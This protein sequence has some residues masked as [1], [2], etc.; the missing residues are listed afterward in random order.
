MIYELYKDE[1]KKVWVRNSYTVKADSIEEAI[2][3]IIDDEGTDHEDFICNTG[4]LVEPSKNKATLEIYDLKDNL[5]YDNKVKIMTKEK[6]I[7]EIESQKFPKIWRKGQSVFNYIDNVYG[8]AR[9]IQFGYGIDCFYNDDC[10]DDFINKAVEL[11]NNG[12]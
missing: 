10:I 12:N 3:K 5:I 11:I 6:L 2:D 7:K 8:V 4:E 9:N 1:L